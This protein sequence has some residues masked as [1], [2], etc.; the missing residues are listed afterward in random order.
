M[1]LKCVGHVVSGHPLISV[2]RV[3]LAA[4][5]SRTSTKG[6]GYFPTVETRVRRAMPLERT[7]VL[8]QQDCSA[9]F[10]AFFGGVTGMG[11]TT[12]QARERSFYRGNITNKHDRGLIIKT[13]PRR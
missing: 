10:G 12:S 9:S 5:T 6:S 8:S 4:I 3:R 11:T 13:K 2:D 1:H 7:E